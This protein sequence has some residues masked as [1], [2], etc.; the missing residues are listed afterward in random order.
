MCGE[1]TFLVYLLN[2]DQYNVLGH[3]VF[4]YFKS[5]P[6]LQSPHIIVYI[7]HVPALFVMSAIIIILVQI[8]TSTICL[9]SQ[10]Y[11]HLLCA[12]FP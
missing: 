12:I 9:S 5:Y 11:I 6:A 8:L 10:C 7:T 4:S 1:N 3:V 2:V